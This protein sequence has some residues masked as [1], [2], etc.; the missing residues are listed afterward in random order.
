MYPPTLPYLKIGLDLHW[1]FSARRTL[2]SKTRESM[3]FPPPSTIIGSL[4]YGLAKTSKL[5]EEVDEASSAELLRKNVFSVHIK[6]NAALSQYSDLTRVWWYRRREGRAKF[7]AVALGKT[8][9][10]NFDRSA[11]SIEALLL[12]KSDGGLEERRLIPA[13]LSVTRIGSKEGVV[14]VR[15]VKQGL[16]VPINLERCGTRYSFWRDLVESVDGVVYEQEV[17]DYRLTPIADYAKATTRVHAYPYDLMKRRP[18][19]V[20]VTLSKR[21]KPYVVDGE[22][23]IVEL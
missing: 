3:L 12:F 13:A 11:P 23:V 8:Y 9:A 1:G 14:C 2:L 5:P 21:A 6:V 20:E 17:V 10:Y 19:T 7:D 22:V 16:A 4:A 18:V 15:H